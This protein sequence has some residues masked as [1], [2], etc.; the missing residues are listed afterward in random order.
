MDG[1]QEETHP[2]EI[3]AGVERYDDDGDWPDFRYWMSLPFW[4]IEEATA[5]SLGSPP[6]IWKRL[7]DSSRGVRERYEKRLTHFQRAVDAGEISEK[8]HPPAVIRWLEDNG[9]PIPQ[10]MECA[11]SKTPIRQTDELGT[12]ERKTLLRMVLGMAMHKYRLDLDREK[13][14]TSVSIAKA[15]DDLG[16]SV[17]DDTIRKKLEK[18]VEEVGDTLTTRKWPPT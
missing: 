6:T 11:P 1:S 17:S 13:Q 16:L 14:G 8:L 10:R 15:L 18:A 5:L 4:T 2:E 9:Y 7:P 12:T 3:A